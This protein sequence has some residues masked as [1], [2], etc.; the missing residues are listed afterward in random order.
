MRHKIQLYCNLNCG[1][2]WSGYTLIPL[3]TGSFTVL[4]TKLEDLFVVKYVAYIFIQVHSQLSVLQ[5]ISI[6]LT[7]Y[8]YSYSFKVTSNKKH[9]YI[10]FNVYSGST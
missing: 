10:Q 3:Q 9:T 6:A 7:V 8:I 4:N 2:E 1:I 5:F